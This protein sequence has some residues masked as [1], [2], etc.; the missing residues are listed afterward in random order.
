MRFCEKGQKHLEHSVSCN[1][2][3]CPAR[4]PPSPGM[5]NT[6]DCNWHRS[7]FPCISKLPILGSRIIS[8]TV[9]PSRTEQRLWQGGKAGEREG[10]CPRP[11]GTGPGGGDRCFSFECN[12]DVVPAWS[13]PDSE[14]IHC[15]SVFRSL[16]MHP[17][18]ILL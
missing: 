2:I 4:I 17:T 11:Q 10:K 5:A 7:R 13:W 12:N 15:L 1:I 14:P 9:C 18:E 3:R 16:S 8:D 6:I